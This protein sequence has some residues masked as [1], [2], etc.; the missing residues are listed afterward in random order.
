MPLDF[1]S[2]GLQAQLRRMKMRRSGLIVE[3]GSRDR[4]VLDELSRRGDIP[5]GWRFRGYDLRVRL[6]EAA[7]RREMHR[8]LHRFGT[9]AATIRDIQPADVVVCV[10]TLEHIGDYASALDLLHDAVRP[11]GR[12]VLSLPNQVGFVGFVKVVRRRKQHAA[13]FRGRREFLRYGRA[14]LTYRDLEP[15]RQPR[16]GDWPPVGFDH[17][18]VTAYIRG[19]FVDSGRWTIER[20]DDTAMGAYR[21]LTIR[22]DEPA[23]TPDR[24][25]FRPRPRHVSLLPSLRAPD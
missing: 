3:W 16:R 15:F 12:L 17:R 13:F 22:R 18:A 25:T 2:R 4:S 23:T 8:R 6:D 21:F 11:G 7:H 19:T 14:V 5:K 20:V 9:D 1:V 24:Q 10:G